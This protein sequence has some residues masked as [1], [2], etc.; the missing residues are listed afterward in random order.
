MLLTVLAVLV[1]DQALKIYIK[2]HFTYG[3]SY[4]VLGHW[5]K[6]NFIENEGMAF[7]MEIAGP[8]GKLILTTFRLIACLAGIFLIKKYIIDAGYKN[9]LI[10]CSSLILAGAL[11]NCVDSV[12]Y[13]KVFSE[14]PFHSGGAAHFVPWGQG[15]ASLFH[16]RVV[17]ML[18]FPIIS[19]HYPQWFPVVGGKEF[20]FFRPIFNIADAAISGGVIAIF[21]FQRSLLQKKAGFEPSAPVAAVEEITESGN[22]SVVS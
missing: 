9:G 15:Y 5:F 8:Y 17:D 10:F 19:G 12:F 14:S 18:Y 21:V 20:E 13:G 7:G 2:T 3:E 4:D 22:H 11:G 1:F 6:L 16:G